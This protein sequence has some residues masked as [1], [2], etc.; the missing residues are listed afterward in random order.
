M[1]QNQSQQLKMF[2]EKTESKSTLR[3]LEIAKKHANGGKKDLMITSSGK[4]YTPI[5]IGV[6]LARNINDFLRRSS[7]EKL[8]IIDPFAGDGRLIV[9]LI[10]NIEYT[11]TELEIVVWDYDNE[12]VQT[13]ARNIRRAADIRG[14]QAKIT[15]ENLNSFSKE[16]I[17]RHQNQYDVVI[18]N[19]PWDIVKPDRKELEA[20]DEV[21]RVEYIKSLKNFSSSLLESFPLSR[22]KLMYGGWGVNLARVGTEIAL[23]LAK[24][25]AIVGVVSPSTLLADQNSINLRSYIFGENFCQ[26]I[27][28]FPAESRLFKSV[29]QPSISFVVIKG[30]KP[31][32]INLA[33]HDDPKNVQ[34]VSS[35]LI[36]IKFL[37]QMDFVIPVNFAISSRQIDIV[38]RLHQLRTINDLGSDR[39]Y[40]LWT[41][42]ELDE[43]GYSSWVATN[44]KTRFVKGV[45]IDRYQIRSNPSFFLKEDCTFNIPD[46]VHF[47]RIGW[48]DVT[49]P[50]QKRRMI[51]TILPQ[52]C[53]AGNSVGIA[54]FRS[55]HPDSHQQLRTLLS[56][57][58]SYVFEFQARLI[59]ATA[60]VSQGIIRKLAIPDLHKDDFLEIT[61]KLV[62]RVMSGD[63]EAEYEVEAMVA[64]QY[65]LDEDD[66]SSILETFPKTSEEEKRRILY[67]MKAN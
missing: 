19:P 36:P 27:D 57:M 6:P 8:R 43:T 10:E 59:L 24:E 22:P 39:K 63:S 52:G 67:F 61:N 54:Y 62:T 40:K 16:L 26:K 51:A 44:G 47:E 66:M 37:R 50:S 29:D 11:V 65:G 30:K 14:V 17:S 4:F 58:S 9:W 42:R 5:E 38:E 35:S 20:L 13:A 53:V 25:N 2:E 55:A 28:I 15:V 23:A 7:S 64:R 12:A 33:I 46:S 49:R 18:T 31:H 56:V 41:G 21:S 3:H 32:D 48:R 60:H 1:L 34:K 45:M